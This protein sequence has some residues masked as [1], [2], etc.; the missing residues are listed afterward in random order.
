MDSAVRIHR[1]ENLVTAMRLQQLETRELLDTALIELAAAK[2]AK[3]RTYFA[4]RWLRERRTER[5]AVPFAH[6]RDAAQP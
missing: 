4:R 2:G 6:H 5:V 1:L 3:D